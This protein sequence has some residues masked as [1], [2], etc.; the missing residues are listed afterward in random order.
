MQGTYFNSQLVT[1]IGVINLS[2]GS[3]CFMYVCEN[4]VDIPVEFCPV[5]ISAGSVFVAYGS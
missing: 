5:Q 3:P 1:S 2:V 4:N